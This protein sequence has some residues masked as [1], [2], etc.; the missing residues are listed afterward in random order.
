MSEIADFLRVRGN[1]SV[2]GAMPPVYRT[3]LAQESSSLFEVPLTILRVWDAFQT[4]IGTAGSDDLGITAGAFGTGTPYVTAGS[5][6]SVGATTRYARFVY[7]VP[8]NYVAG[9]DAQFNLLAGITGGAP[10]AA[11][12]SCTLL[13]VTYKVGTGGLITGS[14]LIASAATDMNFTTFVSVPMAL[15][16]TTLNPGDW[17]DSRIAIACND[18]TASA[19]NVVPAIQRI[20]FAAS[21]QG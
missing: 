11:S 4:P 18:G 3:T 8:M 1:L 10:A 6:G 12:V 17:L 20:Q 21:T 13:Q 5:L 7:Q 9:Q 2:D 15:T 14:N 16:V 19:A